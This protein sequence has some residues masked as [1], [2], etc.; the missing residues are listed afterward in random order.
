MGNQSVI[1]R[2]RFSN[3]KISYNGVV[4]PYAT[5]STQVHSRVGHDDPM[6]Q[7]KI[8]AGQ[9][10]TNLLTAYRNTSTY[11]K[12]E[13]SMI[14]KTGTNKGKTQYT[15]T[16]HPFPSTPT[17]VDSTLVAKASDEATTR[18]LKK[19]QQEAH[20]FSGTTFLGELRD[21][22]RMLKSPAESLA[23]KLN[24]HVKNLSQRKPK[25]KSKDW[26]K[27]IADTWLEG[28]FGWAPLLGDIASIA[29]ASLEKFEKPRIKRLSGFGEREASVHSVLRYTTGYAGVTYVVD[30]EDYESGTVI[31]TA[32]YRTDVDRSNTGLER[33]IAS[34][35]IG[36]W[37][38]AVP[39][40][41]ELLPWSF[42]VD[43][44]SNIG[45]AIN[46]ACVSTANVAWS[47][48]TQIVDRKR[49]LKGITHEIDSALYSTVMNV[50]GRSS[51]RY[52]TVNRDAAS[53]ALPRLRFEL[54]KSNIKLAN[55]AA[56]LTGFL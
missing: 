1:Y 12:S 53:I 13:A 54:P 24:Q 8:K 7:S 15:S 55:V 33:V 20:K 42:L 29:E 37:R 46:V 27:V 52:R 19:I 45:D 6:W 25:V 47:N 31:V 16:G 39:A 17:V 18:L 43:Y 9:G 21:T 5:I 41:W 28:V 30:K 44:F 3:E 2:K 51:S 40:A 38:D 4:L 10:A 26:H 36:T 14:A 23:D 32:G 50:P 48:R 22:A 56:L 11:V 35:G 34:S 49:I